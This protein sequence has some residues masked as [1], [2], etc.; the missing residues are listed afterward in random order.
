MISNKNVVA[1]GN[2]N[3]DAS[4]KANTNKIKADHLEFT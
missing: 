4:K 2:G 1:T 3:N